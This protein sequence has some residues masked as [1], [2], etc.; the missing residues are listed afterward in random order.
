MLDRRSVIVGTV[1]ALVLI[2]PTM[3]VLR[4]LR[5]DGGSSSLG[6]IYLVVV[7]GA[8]LVGAAVAGRR[9]RRTPLANG[10]AVGLASFLLAQVVASVADGDA[11]NVIGVAFFAVAF[12]CLGAIGGLLG[13]A[14]LLEDGPRQRPG[15]GGVPGPPGGDGGGPG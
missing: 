1:V 4:A 10:A 8:V 2:L 14:R 15:P 6:T 7:L 9:Q 12:A 3:F 11:P 13:T 5:S